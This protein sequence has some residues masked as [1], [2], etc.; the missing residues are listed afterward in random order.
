MILY[1][2]WLTNLLNHLSGPSVLSTSNASY[3]EITSHSPGTPN[4]AHNPNYMFQEPYEI[5]IE[6]RVNV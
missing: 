2:I 3:N 1:I 6:V 5:P 4:P